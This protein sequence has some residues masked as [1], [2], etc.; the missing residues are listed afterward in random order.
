[1]AKKYIYFFGKGKAEGNA[2]MKDI[3]GGKGAN[4]AE[5]TN[6]G[7]PVPAGFTISTQMCTYYYKNNKK[8]PLEF[9]EEVKK[10]MRKIEEAMG[11][12]FGSKDNPL[13]VS[14][15]SGAA[16]SMPGMMD[17]ILNLGLND[18]TIKG[19]IAQT[20][21]ER[22]VFDAY[23]RFIQ[24][25]S[26]VVLKIEKDKFEKIIEE[27]KKEKGVRLDV[28]LGADDWRDITQKFKQLFKETMGYNFPQDVWKQ[29]KMAIL[30]VFES[31]NNPR[32]ITYRNLNKIPHTLGTAVNVQAMVFGNMG[33]D[34][35]TG[36]AF[37][38]NPS[39]GEKKFYGE[40]LMN[41]QGEDVV[42]GIRTPQSIEELKKTMPKIY[43]Q[44]YRIQKKLEKHFKDM[45]DLEFTIEKGTLYLL[46][47]RTGKRTA[48]ASVKIA[49]DMVKEGLITKEEAVKRVSPQSLDQLLHPTIDPSSKPIPVAKGLAASPGAAVGEVVFTAEEAIEEAEKGKEVI[50]VRK[51]TSPEDVGGMA[52]SCGILTSTG[53]LTSHAAVV[54]RGMGK[55]CVVG[56]SE[57]IVNEEEGYFKVKDNLIKKGQIISID[58]STGEVFLEKVKLVEPKLSGEFAQL[59]KWADQ[60]RKL[61]VRTNADTPYDAKIARDFGAEG[62]GLCRTEHMFFGKDRLPKMQRMILSESEEE[63]EKALKEL[64][65]LQREDF[66]GIFK[67]MKGFPVTIRLLDPPLHEFLPKTDEE[68]EQLSQKIGI[69]P[70][71]IKDTVSSLHEFNPMLG[72]RGCRLGI[73][74]P[75]I[76]KM[77]AQAIFEAA[78]YF[79]KEEKI[80]I[81]PEVMVP[82]VG[83][84]NEIIIT[85]NYIDEVAREVS[86]KY[87]VK[88][89]YSVGTMVEVPRA[90]LTA[91][92]I[93]AYA[94]F[95]SFGTND[96]TQMTFG[97]SRDD[98]G[99]FLK[100]YLEN[101]LLPYDPFVSVDETGVGKL[102]EMAVTLGRKTRKN[103]KVG[104]CGE[105]GGDP[106]SVRFCHRIGLDYVSCS[107]FRVPIARLAA[108]QAALEDKEIRK[109]KKRK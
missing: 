61:G 53:G 37:T 20:N 48:Q 106:Q 89:N 3:L 39:T 5:M 98:A 99:R 13:L 41:A 14:V 76:I 40:F 63:K 1:M 52:T 34:S 35:G 7:I 42:A 84:V 103:L 30:A 45:Q 59:M 104:I 23:R 109:G 102:M 32:A 21:D 51:E 67:V 57:V 2:K 69:S 97:F 25:F 74:Y 108:A 54:G 36:V 100:V 90:A 50:L 88:L 19:L 77:Q 95:F 43:N 10:Y 27:K 62:I 65:P 31:W 93:A 12:K 8:L 64:L 66:K 49:V 4:L 105:Q 83:H 38:R 28:E 68:I 16:I 81:K 70:Q 9:F 96:L 33:P 79:I 82:L 60:I 91:D 94:E 101:K 11:K 85:K 47:T 18:T 87:K 22:F 107:P 78:A 86:K 46:Q 92:E 58:G 24:M 6:L 73:V 72:F 55:P 26:D 29:L 44:L 80:K 56:C 15:R 71:K 75:E 17:T